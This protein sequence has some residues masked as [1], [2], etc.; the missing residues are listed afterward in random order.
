[1]NMR[2]VIKR[3]LH[4]FTEDITVRKLNGKEDLQKIIPML[5]RIFWT[6]K[7]SSEIIWQEIQP[8]DLKNTFILELNNKPIGFYFLREKNIPEEINPVLFSLFKNKKGIEGVALGILPEYQKLG[9]GRKLIEIPKKLNYDYVWGW[10]F[11]D[12]G[13]LPQWLRRR[14]FYGFD[15]SDKSYLTYEFLK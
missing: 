15:P 14:K 5:S 6:L 12:L 3:I 4:E 1:M 7:K 11:E 2:S 8:V 10:Q 9:Y 13:N